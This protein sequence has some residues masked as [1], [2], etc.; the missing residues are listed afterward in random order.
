MFFLVY[1]REAHALDSAMPMEFGLVEDP[2]TEAERSAVAGTCVEGLDLPMPALVDGLDD[3]VGKAYGGWPDRLYLI[4]QDGKIAY[5][6][7]RG[8]AGFDPEAWEK[9]IEAELA[10]IARA[11]AARKTPR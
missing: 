2:V 7:A 8:P 9:A 6:G 11:T 1:I 5:A 4:G 3:A 10:R